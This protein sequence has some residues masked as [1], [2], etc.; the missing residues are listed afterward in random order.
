MSHSFYLELSDRSRDYTKI[1]GDLGKIALSGA[2]ENPQFDGDFFDRP[3]RHRSRY[4]VVNSR[5][6]R[7]MIAKNIEYRRHPSIKPETDLK[8]FPE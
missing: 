7:F 4:R 2:I 5:S 6:G 3:L 8:S 1:K